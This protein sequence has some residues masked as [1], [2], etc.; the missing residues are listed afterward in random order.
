VASVYKLSGASRWMEGQGR[1]Y[2][3]RGSIYKLCGVGG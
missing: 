1:V 2:K 3:R